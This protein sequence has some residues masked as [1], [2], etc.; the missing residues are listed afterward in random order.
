MAGDDPLKDLT[1]WI[2]AKANMTIGKDLLAGAMMPD[3]DIKVTVALP[4][5]EDPKTYTPRQT[6]LP[7]E[8]RT[9]GK[10][11]WEARDEAYRVYNTVNNSIN[12]T[13]DD[14]T[15]MHAQGTGPRFIGVNER[16]HYEFSSNLTFNL[17]KG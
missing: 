4:Q 12:S 8:L 16:Q 3:A 7:V 2:A 14:L 1:E 5:A 6:T 10:T 13:H 15:V 11:Y 17:M 9:R